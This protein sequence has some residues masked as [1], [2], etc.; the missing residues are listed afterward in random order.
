MITK[1]VVKA[2]KNAMKSK[3]DPEL[4][5]VKVQV[6]QLDTV[7]NCIHFDRFSRTIRGAR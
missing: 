2:A 6:N 5:R 7:E 4:E 3:K 1:K